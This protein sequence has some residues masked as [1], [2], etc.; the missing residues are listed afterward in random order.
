M[1][2]LIIDGKAEAQ[3]IREQVRKDVSVFQGKFGFAPSLSVI[4]VGDNIP[5]NIY[6]RNKARALED[7]GFAFHLHHLPETIPEEELLNLI[8]TLNQS[9]LVHGILV[10]LPLPPHLNGERILEALDPRK[11]VDGLHPHNLGLLV[12]GQGK[13]LS[14]GMIPC[15]PKGCLLLLQS[16]HQTLAGKRAVVIGRSALVGKPLALLLTS[17]DVTVTLAHSKTQGLKDLCRGAD[18]LV[19][20]VGVPHL[21]RGDWVKPQATVIDVGINRV[22]AALQGDVA[23]GEVAKVAQFVT[24]VPGGVGP[25]TIACLLANTLEAAYGFILRG[26]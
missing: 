1:T 22:G 3:K 19:A 25:M 6:V 16:C 9:P 12:R 20:A 10:Q 18:I 23:F 15:T 26:F 7:A 4:L 8:H 14:K 13:N 5:S 21:V 2:A 24:P 11:D 17:L